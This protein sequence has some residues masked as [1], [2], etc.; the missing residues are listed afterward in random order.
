MNKKAV[1]EINF[2]AAFLFARF[3]KKMISYAVFVKYTFTNT[4][5][6]AKLSI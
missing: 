6:T 4:Q 5:Q 3:E 1:R 2:P